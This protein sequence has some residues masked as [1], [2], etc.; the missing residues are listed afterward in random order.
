MLKGIAG[1]CINDSDAKTFLRDYAAIYKLKYMYIKESHQYIVF[2][3]SKKGFGTQ[4]IKVSVKF[5]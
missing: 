5:Y 2:R 1:T 4:T 3:L